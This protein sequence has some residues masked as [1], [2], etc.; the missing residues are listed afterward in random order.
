VFDGLLGYGFDLEPKASLAQ[1]RA[2]APDGK[3]I[4]FKLRSDV[5]FHGGEPFSSA[6]VKLNVMEV[7]KKNQPRGIATFRDVTAVDTPDATTAVFRLANPAPYF[8]LDE[9]AGWPAPKAA[10]TPM[11]GDITARPDKAQGRPW[12]P[13]PNHPLRTVT[14]LPG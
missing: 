1:C 8:L 6:D 10:Q 9:G 14:G 3:A 2:A 7:L 13:S 4:T 12:G 5:K 11:R